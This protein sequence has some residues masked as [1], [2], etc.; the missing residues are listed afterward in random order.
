MTKKSRQ[1]LAGRGLWGHARTALRVF[2]GI[3]SGVYRATD[4]RVA[5][6][7]VGSPVVLLVTMCDVQAVKHEGLRFSALLTEGDTERLELARV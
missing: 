2:G 5:G 6:R 4:D 1:V 3:H 7:L